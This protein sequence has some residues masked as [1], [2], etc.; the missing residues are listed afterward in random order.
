MTHPLTKPNEGAAAPAYQRLQRAIEDGADKQD[1]LVTAIR[2]MIIKDRLVHPRTGMTFVP[3]PLGAGIRIDYRNDLAPHTI[4]DHALQ[5]LVR[6]AKYKIEHAR[7]LLEPADEGEAPVWKSAL[8]ADILNVS[9][10]NINFGQKGNPRFL[11][12]IVGS[13]LRGFL[14][15]QFNLHLAS[16]PLLRA[17]VGSCAAAG[18]VPVD[19]KVTPVKFSLKCVIPEV[20]EPVPGEFVCVGVEWT[21]SDFGTGQMRVSLTLW[22]AKGGFTVLDKAL[23]RTHIGRVLRDEDV[24]DVEL[25]EATA[26]KEADTQ[27]SFIADTVKYRLDPDYVGK[28]LV[29]I[30]DAHQEQISW[31]R[32]YGQFEK[33]L[34]KRELEAVE[35]SQKERGGVEDLPPMQWDDVLGGIPTRWWA[36]SVLAKLASQADTADRAAELERASGTFLKMKEVE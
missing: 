28:V 5:R 17:F 12:R 36:S 3:G 35:K 23:A 11:H 14:S 1:R 18:A 34:T 21:N 10:K 8:L 24:G 32:L 33:L 15:R 30:G 29:A 7:Y 31:D 26:K 20:F 9:F 4:H 2:E 6:A 27:A 25:S 22:R 16:A 19:A 13:E